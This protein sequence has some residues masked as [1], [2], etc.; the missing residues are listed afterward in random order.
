MKR[1]QPAK[2]PKIR[3]IISFVFKDAL[4]QKCHDFVVLL[5]I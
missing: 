3:R 4:I 1:T 2:L 5:Y